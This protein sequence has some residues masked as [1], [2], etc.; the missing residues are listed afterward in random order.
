MAGDKG[1]IGVGPAAQPTLIIFGFI[2]LI[3]QSSS[4]VEG[5][6]ERL[7]N[8]WS[9]IKKYP[10]VEGIRDPDPKKCRAGDPRV[11]KIEAA[12]T[13]FRNNHDPRVEDNPLY[14]D[15]RGDLQVTLDQVTD[16]MVGIVVDHDIITKAQFSGPGVMSLEG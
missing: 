10:G 13:Q 6:A 3:T 16:Y 4:S 5:R 11:P 9:W 7:F 12:F 15:D 14:V 1:F 8:I 2:K